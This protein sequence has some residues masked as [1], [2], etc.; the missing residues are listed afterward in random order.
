MNELDEYVF[1]LRT[2]FGKFSRS[3]VL[4][5]TNYDFFTERTKGLEPTTFVDIKSVELRDILRQI[6]EGVKVVC[7]REEMPSV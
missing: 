1:V 4:F 5:T 7:L 3:P 6:F 2:R